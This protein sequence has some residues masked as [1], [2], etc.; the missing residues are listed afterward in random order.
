[1]TLLAVVGS[2][3][4]VARIS[5]PGLGVEN[6]GDEQANKGIPDFG[7]DSMIL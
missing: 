1:M 5:K 2:A 4:K 7:Y 3:E 6:G